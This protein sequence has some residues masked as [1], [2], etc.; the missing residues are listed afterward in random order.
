MRRPQWEP[1][2]P[3]YDSNYAILDEAGLAVE[4]FRGLRPIAFVRSW[5][6]WLWHALRGITVEAPR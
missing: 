4:R 2:P 5:A 6:W 1:Q 3:E